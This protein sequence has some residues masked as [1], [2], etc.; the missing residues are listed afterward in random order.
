MKKN[1]DLTPKIFIKN[2]PDKIFCWV[3]LFFAIIFFYAT[4]TFISVETFEANVWWI[5]ALLAIPTTVLTVIN[6]V[7]TKGVEL[8]WYLIPALGLIGAWLISAD[9][10][11]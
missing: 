4:E 1:N 7:K 6:W 11:V 3:W 9:I 8:F 10:I 2:N 5:G